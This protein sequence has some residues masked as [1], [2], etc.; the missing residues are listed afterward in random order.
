MKTFYAIVI[1]GMMAVLAMLTYPTLSGFVSVTD[2]SSFLPLVTAAFT[3]LPY[4]F[5]GIV[6]YAMIRK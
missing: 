1:G 6:I 5:L 3:L 4:A 2:T